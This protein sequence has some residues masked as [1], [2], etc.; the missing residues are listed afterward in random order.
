MKIKYHIVFVL[1]FIYLFAIPALASGQNDSLSVFQSMYNVEIPDLAKP[2][3]IQTTLPSAQHYSDVV[4][5]NETGKFIGLFQKTVFESQT[6]FTLSILQA[7]PLIGNWAAIVDQD[8]N[9]SAEFDLDRD[10]GQA[11]LELKTSQPL[12]TSIFYLSVD[13]NVALPHRIQIKAL[14]NG[15][16]KTVLAQARMTSPSMTFPETNASQWRIDLEHGQPLRVSEMRFGGMDE[17]LKALGAEIRW[18]A[19]PNNT[20]TLYADAKASPSILTEEAGQLTGK[21]IEVKTGI[22]GAKENNPLFKEPDADSDGIPD[23]LDNCVAIENADQKDVDDN[24]RGDACED[25]DGDL[26]MNNLDNCPDHPNRNQK[27]TDEDGIGD[28]CDDEE[29]RLTEANPWLPWAGM[30]VAAMLIGIMIYQMIHR[31]KSS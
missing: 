30:G 27:D 18:L 12:T 13:K 28:V 21:E 17:Q 2:T 20:Y 9:T 16:W 8:Y 29:S 15:N 1:T 11:F 23:L 19:Q 10:K 7:S 22:L 14:V 25:F 3:V 26:K 6:P 4:Q 31:R 5:E 24:G